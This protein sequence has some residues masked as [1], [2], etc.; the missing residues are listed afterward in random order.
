MRSG[1]LLNSSNTKWN[2]SELELHAESY[3]NFISIAS[4]FYMSNRVKSTCWM[5]TQ[6]FLKIFSKL[7]FHFHFPHLTQKYF[8]KWSFVLS[9]DIIGSR[10]NAALHVKFSSPCEF[11]PQGC[12]ENT[13]C[14][15]LTGQRRWLGVEESVTSIASSL[16]I[17]ES[18]SR[19]SF[20]WSAEDIKL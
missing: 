3:F 19:H 2:F 6:L 20:F 9:M 1:S 8:F 15:F 4:R 13:L 10:M 16:K 18:S 17:G 14:S 7:N 12:T 11:R 5:W